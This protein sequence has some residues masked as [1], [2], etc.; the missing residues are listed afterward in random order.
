MLPQE[1]KSITWTPC[2]GKILP[3][4]QGVSP[5]IPLL[6]Q[7]QAQPVP[8]RFRP[9]QRAQLMYPKTRSGMQRSTVAPGRLTL[10]AIPPITSR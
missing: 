10:M 4:P 7:T 6:F 9:R 3:R 5:P 2:L 8:L 1:I